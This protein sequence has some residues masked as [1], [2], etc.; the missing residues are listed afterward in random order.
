MQNIRLTKG[1]IAIVDEEDYEYLNNFKWRALEVNGFV[2]AVR[3]DRGK[4]DWKK[5]IFM[6]RELMKADEDVIIVHKNGD[7]LDN[8]K[9]NLELIPIIREAHYK[10]VYYIPKG[11][12]KFYS[13]I[14]FAGKQKYLGSFET[15]KEAQ[16]AYEKATIAL[17]Y[18]ESIFTSEEHIVR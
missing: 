6:H 4:G 14:C 3:S 16:E 13:S 1:F 7:G 15:E 8:R 18:G 9:E 11:K 2:Y 17:L 5:N 10:G 12:K